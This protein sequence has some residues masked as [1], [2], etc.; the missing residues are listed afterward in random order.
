[1]GVSGIEEG[2][3][4]PSEGQVQRGRQGSEWLGWSG[5]E[6]ILS[7]HTLQCQRQ[8]PGRGFLAL[9]LSLVRTWADLAM[10]ANQ[11]APLG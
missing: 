4:Q 10:H 8:A 3:S 2:G 9:S 7:A 1:M 6:E 11:E 5:L